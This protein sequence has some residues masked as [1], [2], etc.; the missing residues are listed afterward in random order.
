M[1]SPAAMSATTS[2][3]FSFVSMNRKMEA[4]PRTRSKD[5]MRF[6]SE[7]MRL[8]YKKISIPYSTLQ[9]TQIQMI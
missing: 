1:A 4:I 8:D 6:I 2:G 3:T 7:L 5:K 9:Q